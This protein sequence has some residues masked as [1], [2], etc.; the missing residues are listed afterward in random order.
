MRQCVLGAGTGLYTLSRQQM[1]KSSASDW[2][3]STPAVV[4]G[5]VYIG[6]ME[7]MHSLNRDTLLLA[8]SVPLAAPVSQ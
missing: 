3:W 5:L 7:S 1:E 2:I 8:T 6:A 4:D